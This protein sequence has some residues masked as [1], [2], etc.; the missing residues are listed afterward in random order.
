MALRWIEGWEGATTAVTH[1]ARLYPVFTGT[2]SAE[3]GASEDAGEAVS[4]G[5]A[6]MTTP[7]LVV[8]PENSWILGIAFRPDHATAINNPDIPYVAFENSDGEQI[9]FEFVDAD[10]A[11]SKPGGQY[12][13]IRAMRG[14][15]ELASTNERFLLGTVDENWIFFEFKVTIHDSTGS[16][17]GRYSPCR[18]TALGRDIALTWD[19]ATSGI[20]T[21][22]QSSA[23][24]DRFTLSMDTGNLGNPV[25]TDDIY[26]CDSTGAKNNDYLGRILIEGQKPAGDGDTTDWVLADAASTQ[27]AWDESTTTTDDDAR[28]TSDTPTDVHLAT[29]DPLVV[30]TGVNSNVIGVRHDI[31]AHMETSGDF[32]IAHMFRKTTGTPAETDAG[33]DLN[34]ASTTY[35]GS[36]AVLEDDP[37]TA[38]DWDVADLNS[39]QYGVRNDG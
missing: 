27:Q 29:V 2:F 20:D 17:E 5:D 31:I 11:S 21:Q 12:Y 7:V 38:T 25:A 10:P 8:A 15:T 4:G 1:H 23:G 36:A 26:V 35:E 16:F 13:K 6:V 28:V 34:V 39:Y 3:D 32:D 9:R 18:K 22:N 24:A 19:A 14:V 33:V 37:N 30:I